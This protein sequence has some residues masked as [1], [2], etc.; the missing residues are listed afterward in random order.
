MRGLALNRPPRD[1]AALRRR[2]GGYSFYVSA[3]VKPPNDRGN[4]I[5]LHSCLTVGASVVLV[6]VPGQ[7]MIDML[8]QCMAHGRKAGLMAAIGVPY[9]VEA[10]SRSLV[11]ANINAPT[12][13]TIE[14]FRCRGISG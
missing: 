9:L 14:A 6:V 13:V 12:R 5:T 1:L 2:S 8:S 3:P 7:V 11:A 10:M 4:N